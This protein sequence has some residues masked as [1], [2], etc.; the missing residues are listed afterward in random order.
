MSKELILFNEHQWQEGIIQNGIIKSSKLHNRKLE[1]DQDYSVVSDVIKIEESFAKYV[2]S[3]KNICQEV[4]I[5]KQ[6]HDFI[7]SETFCNFKNVFYD[8][9]GVEITT[10]YI[11]INF[12]W[13]SMQTPADD[14]MEI[15]LSTI[16]DIYLEVSLYN[17]N[18]IKL[19][20]FDGENIHTRRHL[21][22]SDD[23]IGNINNFISNQMNNAHL[24]ALIVD[25]K[26]KI[27]LYG[28]GY[29][30]NWISFGIKD[31]TKFISCS[32]NFPAT[33]ISEKNFIINKI[34]L[35]GYYAGKVYSSKIYDLKEPDTFIKKIELEGS[36]KEKI[37]DLFSN[38]E[39]EIKLATANQKKD[40]EF[41]KETNIVSDKNTFSF[42][43]E[44]EL[45]GRFLKIDIY[46]NSQY[47]LN[48]IDYLNIEYKLPSQEREII[49]DI[50]KKTVTKNIGPDGGVIDLQEELFNVRFYIPPLS[51]EETKEIK[52]SRLSDKDSRLPSDCI[53]IHFQPSGLE[54]KKKC[55]FEIDYTG[56]KLDKFQTEEGIELIY[57]KK[58]PE[59]DSDEEINIEDYEQ[60]SSIKDTEDKKIIGYINHF[61]LY[62]LKPFDNEY[63][64]KTEF[65][66]STMPSWMKLQEKDSVFQQF[67]NYSLT[68]EHD[69]LL[70]IKDKALKQKLIDLADTNQRFIS[71]KIHLKHFLNDEDQHPSSLELETKAFYKGKNINI[72]FDMV[73]FFS[74]KE[75]LFYYDKEK[76]IVHFQQPY[77]KDEL[78]LITQNV[79]ELKEPLIR[80]HIWNT[81]DEFAL[82]M[83]L[84]RLPEEENASL[85]RRI[86]DVR[87]NLPGAHHKGLKNDI[88]RQL[89]LKKSEITINTLKNKDYV[90]SLYDKDDN[91]RPKLKKIIH[92]INQK[93]SLFWDEA[94]WDEA[95]WDTVDPRV[96]DFIRK[97]SK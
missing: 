10:N 7:D 70:N 89:G 1:P 50:P 64:P 37:D 4:S 95:Y 49:Y 9:S 12:D 51:L 85:K 83:G 42:L 73:E 67:L 17:K 18:K 81:F 47:S 76:E 5:Q 22:T 48:A 68:R 8:N 91:P 36:L 21:K 30:S 53:G 54:F 82:L 35:D 33:K 87:K 25:K 16:D 65:E 29:K 58:E 61:S 57:I 63:S 66:A 62:C 77:E 71:F 15:K 13:E 84:E 28:N 20:V 78:K 69:D 32:Y 59:E 24:E 46:I 11:N 34:W 2:S 19:E 90:D 23:S 94:K 80:H 43:E 3:N 88:A 60:I 45:H 14:V 96:Y 41:K 79:F 52:V 97:S 31:S 55:L 38:Y 40:L 72:T 86:L 44:I 93:L 39:I 74:S 26:L 56:L 75:N 27:R 6:S 92:R